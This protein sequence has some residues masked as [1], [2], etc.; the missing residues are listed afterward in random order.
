VIGLRPLGPKGTVVGVRLLG[1]KFRI[2]D[3]TA[4]PGTTGESPALERA[5]S[6]VER[7]PEKK[8]SGWLA[9]TTLLLLVAIAGLAVLIANTV[10]GDKVTITIARR[11]IVPQNEVVLSVLPAESIVVGESDGR[12]LGST[13][14]TILV[15]SEVP[16]SVL[17]IA[18]GREPQRFTLPDRGHVSTELA[19]LKSE[20]CE[21]DLDVPSG[22][23][24]ES[25]IGDTRALGSKYRVPGAMVLR[26]TNIRGAWIVR[27]PSLGGTEAQKITSTAMMTTPHAT[28]SEP[29][30]ATV[31]I[32]GEKVGIVP[33]QA[34]IS[35]GFAK[36]KI[37]LGDSAIERWI[38]I[39]T[40]TELRL[41]NPKGRAART[42][43]GDAGVR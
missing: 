5:L 32:D 35:A 33:L 25:V 9:A 3:V 20:P 24:L 23:Q 10:A 27:C 8:G 14:L 43:V 4:A 12:I 15:P 6:S 19:P 16:I 34:S 40:N 7:P 38:P 11:T 39:F 2:V 13:P 31:T 41:P 42:A 30:G 22:A 1:P 21:V 36:F 29:T 18:P 37:E 26:A 17:V 28:I